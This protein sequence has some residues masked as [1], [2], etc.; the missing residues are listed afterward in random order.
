MVEERLDRLVRQR[1]DRL[2][3]DQLLGIHHVAVDRVLGRG[4]RPQAALDPSSGGR[5]VV[6]FAALE[7]LLIGVIRELRVGDGGLPAR[8][9]GLA[10][11]DRVERLVHLGV[12][13][14]HEEGRDGC[15]P[16]DLAAGVTQPPQAGDVGV[17]H[18]AVDVDAEHER[19]VDVDPLRD[20]VLDRGQAGARGRDLHEH[21]RPP[22]AAPQVSGAIQG[23]GGVIGQVGLNLDRDEAIGA[24]RLVVDRAQDV[25]GVADV[26]DLDL[27]EDPPR[28]VPGLDLAPDEVVVLAAGNG[29]AEDGRVAG[30]A[31]D[32]SLHPLGQRPAV[33]QLA[34]DEIDPRAL[35]LLGVQPLQR[36]HDRFSC[37]RS[38]AAAAM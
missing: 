16:P 33:D 20:R 18:L 31:A 10:A 4:A 25:G 22:E 24:I 15:H 19:D 29:L 28:V 37:T 7:D 35:V 17:G 32:P 11:A 3:P 30:E 5:Q 23:G 36:V 8:L 6:E 14:A 27:L 26:G 21:V 34:V 13:P 1:V 38:R 9:E 12:H 2:R